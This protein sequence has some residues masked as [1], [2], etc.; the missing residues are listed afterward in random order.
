MKIPEPLK[1]N[2]ND[3]SNV[4]RKD[5]AMQNEIKQDQTQILKFERERKGS[6]TSI[7]I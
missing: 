3:L 7:E 2:G 4:L 6:T 5:P 1:F